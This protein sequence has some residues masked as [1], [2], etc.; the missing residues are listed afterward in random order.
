MCYFVISFLKIFPENQIYN[1]NGE[2]SIY[3]KDMIKIV[4]DESEGFHFRLF[5][6][7][8]VFKFAMTFYQK[9]NGNVEFTPDQVDS[10]TAE[11]TFPIHPWWEEHHIKITSFRQGVRKMMEDENKG[12]LNNQ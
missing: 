8:N 5:L 11:E 10:L 6:P 12:E 1:I 3:F 9:I 4:L 7:V 2:E